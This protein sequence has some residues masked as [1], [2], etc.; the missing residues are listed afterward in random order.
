[1][2]YYT[3]YIITPS[4]QRPDCLQKCVNS[5]LEQPYQN[6]IQI[7]VNDSPDF[8]YTGFEMT[9]KYNDRRII[10]LKNTENRGVNFS[11]NKILDYISQQQLSD[12]DFVILLDDDDWLA[13]NALQI[14]AAKIAELKK[15]NLP[16]DWLLA[17][18]WN[19][20]TNK[21]AARRKAADKTI[22]RPFIDNVF[23]RKLAGDAAQIIKAKLAVTARF[24]RTIKQSEELFYFAQLKQCAVV[25]VVVVKKVGYL[26]GGLTE[27]GKLTYRKN[28]WALWREFFSLSRKTYS[29]FL[30][31]I[32]RSI[33]ISCLNY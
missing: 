23:F 7:I 9:E 3:F 14:I 15:E 10:Y 24:C 29:F 27:Q 5:V 32:L 21:D 22:I 18:A 25:V 1:M 4:Y 11:R 6:W 8:D 13:D 17:T 30:Y 16:T 26:A 31:L 20:A 28:T 19:E 12:N 33:R 2:Y